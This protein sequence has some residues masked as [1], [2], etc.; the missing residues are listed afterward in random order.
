MNLIEKA[1]DIL[2]NNWNGMYT[3]PSKTLYPHQWSWDSAL[4]SIGNSYYNTDRAIKELEHLFRAQWSN[5]MVP[6]IVFSNNQ[7]Y[8]PSAEFYDS[9]RAKEA[10]N[11]PTSTIT[12]PPVHALAFL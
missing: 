9:K 10:P 7:G 6:S 12:N 5:G 1:K 4:I 11:I 2:D 3:I 8:F